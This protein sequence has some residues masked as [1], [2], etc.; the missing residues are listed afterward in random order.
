M[1]LVGG[2]PP[3]SLGTVPFLPA[4]VAPL[5]SFWKL[6]LHLLGGGWGGKVSRF[7][8]VCLPS[9]FLFFFRGKLKGNN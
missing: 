1:L 7:P 9:L 4:Y 6:L 2:I 5:F 3:A 8:L